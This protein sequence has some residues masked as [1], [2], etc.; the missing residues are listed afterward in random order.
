MLRLTLTV[1]FPASIVGLL[2]LSAALVLIAETASEPTTVRGIVSST[3]TPLTGVA[4]F[5][6]GTGAVHGSFHP[7]PIAFGLAVHMGVAVVFGLAGVAL[8]LAVQGPCCGA[9]GGAVQGVAYALFLQ[10]FFLALIVNGVQGRLTV[11][12]SLPPWAWWVAHAVY[13]AVMGV[14]ASRLLGTREVVA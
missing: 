9:V 6:F 13:G 12:E 11:Y 14:M 1:G 4:G 10:V 2:I 5:F 7:L 8:I 3:W